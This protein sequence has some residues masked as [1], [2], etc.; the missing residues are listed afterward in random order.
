[1]DL[2]ARPV[3]RGQRD[4]AGGDGPVAGKADLAGDVGEG[5]E[6]GGGVEAVAGG[7]GAQEGVGLCGGRAPEVVVLGEAGGD[8]GDGWGEG[9]LGG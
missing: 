1:M 5:D 9:G 4:G 7:V 6:K 3:G 2:H 8:Y